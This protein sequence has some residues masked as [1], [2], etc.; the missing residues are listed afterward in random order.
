MMRAVLNKSWRD[1]VMNKELYISVPIVRDIIH[2]QRLKFSGHCLG[3]RS[4]RSTS[5][6]PTTCMKPS[7]MVYEH[8]LGLTK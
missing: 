7:R 2:Q 5:M 4:K 3:R 1:H 6:E 8:I